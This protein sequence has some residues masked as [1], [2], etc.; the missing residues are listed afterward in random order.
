MEL[1]SIQVLK[2][3]VKPFII[4]TQYQPTGSTIDMMDKFE[5]VLQKI[6]LISNES[7]CYW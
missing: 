2:P 6:G 5:A 4:C 3:R 7:R 1:I